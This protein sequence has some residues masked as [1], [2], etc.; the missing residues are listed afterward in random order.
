MASF[1]NRTVSVMRIVCST[2][3]RSN[4]PLV[5]WIIPVVSLALGRLSA[6]SYHGKAMTSVGGST[7][8]LVS[9]T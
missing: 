6:D 9:W 4:C 8:E 1:P 2:R 5:R 3:K 7:V